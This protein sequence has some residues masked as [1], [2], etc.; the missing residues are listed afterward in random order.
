M[1]GRVLRRPGGR[2][3]KADGLEM[4]VKTGGH[5]LLNILHSLEVDYIFG[6]TG[7]GMPDIQDAMVVVKPPKWIQ[8][9]HEFV[10]V[11]AAMGYALASGRVGVAMVDRIVGTLNAAGAF[12]PA[13]LTSSPI[14]VLAS[15]NIPGVALPTP[16]KEYHYHSNQVHPVSPWV[17][18]SAQVNSLETL[19]QDVEKAFFMA[20]S[21]PR[22]PTYL[23]LRQDLM[24]TEMNR[25]RMPNPGPRKLAP[26][27]PDDATL[28]S[29]VEMI[30][31]SD[32]PQL[33]TAQLGR[34]PS[35]VRSA[36]A[37]AHL[38]G[39]AV[40]ETRFFM[41]YP[42][43]DPLHVGYVD[44]GSSPQLLPSTDL[45]LALE[46][47]L[48]PNHG[49]KAG[50]SVVD[51]TSDPMHR[52]DVIAG[53][54]YG[55]SQFRAA[56]RAVGSPGLTLDRLVEL[57]RKKMTAADR[58]KAEERVSRVRKVHRMVIRGWRKEARRNLRSG[59]LNGWSVGYVMRKNWSRDLILVDGAQSEGEGLLK[60]TELDVPGTCFGNPSS[61]LGISTGVA[62]GVALADT[63]YERVRDK[64]GYKVGA[65]GPSAQTVVCSLG[66]GEAI[67]GNLSSALWTCKHY[68]IGVLYVVLNNACWGEE[69]ASIER[70]PYH[71]SRDAS[72]FEALDIDQPRLDFVNI[73]RGS[74]VRAQR[75]ST[76]AELESLFPTYLRRAKSGEPVLLDVWMPKFTGARPSVVP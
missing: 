9:L 67:M 72:D 37:F 42:L 53:G 20:L 51:I 57:G 71:W 16:G 44:S 15:S 25:G 27:V 76:V 34:D 63:R 24:V 65:I 59:I 75:V 38:F 17:K 28:A 12:Y 8:G 68:G 48:L 62:Y 14:A 3:A 26:T 5:W 69:W 33:L 10:S 22:A 36:I 4:D 74:G 7:A 47:G 13:F 70:S 46:M 23:T 21:E 56:V 73:A 39:V 1:D 32:G 2:T 45:V 49:F 55:S 18:W 61:H 31:S 40:G 19:S 29:I 64:G 66:D 50:V 41:N 30:L 52:Q 43:S 58:R 35:N 60:S 11:S 54:D 6:T